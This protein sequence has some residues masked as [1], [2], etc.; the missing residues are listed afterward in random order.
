MAK[1]TSAVAGP[2]K[3]SGT[4]TAMMFIALLA[5][6]IGCALLFMEWGEYDSKR[7]PDRFEAFKTL[8]PLNTG[9]DK[10]GATGGT[11]PADTKPGDQ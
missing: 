5:L 10:G 9:A 1:T 4:Y 7:G 6:G 2:K 8:P 3:Q 11:K